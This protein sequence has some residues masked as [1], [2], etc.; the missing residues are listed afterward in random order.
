MKKFIYIFI[1]LLA[2]VVATTQK[3]ANIF[4]DDSQEL[5]FQPKEGDCFN[6]HILS[7]FF[8]QP[9]GTNNGLTFFTISSESI[10]FSECFDN[11][12]EDES[13]LLIGN[14]FTSF[15]HFTQVKLFDQ[16]LITTCYDISTT[17]FSYLAQK[18]YIALEVFRL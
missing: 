15:H 1:V 9:F 5:S 10:D 3:T 8:V 7:K 18:K 13:E 11:D 16:R 14:K 6:C 4:S 17:I 12:F 2:F